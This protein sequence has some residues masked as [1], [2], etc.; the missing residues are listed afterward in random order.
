VDH[1]VRDHYS[2]G[3]PG[4]RSYPRRRGRHQCTD[5]GGADP[6]GFIKGRM[7][8]RYFMEIRTAPQWLTAVWAEI[9]AIYLQQGAF[10]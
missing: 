3:V 5:H 1:P 8:I 10:N 2:F 7:N 6:L 9:L 4:S